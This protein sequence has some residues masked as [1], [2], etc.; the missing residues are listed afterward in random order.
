[1]TLHDKQISFSK[2]GATTEEIK[3]LETVDTILENLDGILTDN[4][5][6]GIAFKDDN[7]AVSDYSGSAISDEEVETAQFV[8]QTV[9]DM[10][11]AKKGLC[12][13]GV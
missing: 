5:A 8:I 7:E 12:F 3:A 10:I 2:L 1:M 13:V 11:R 6:E 4:D 9:L